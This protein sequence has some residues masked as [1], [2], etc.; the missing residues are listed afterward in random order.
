MSGDLEGLS[1]TLV[2]QKCAMFGC[3]QEYY[4][5][6]AIAPATVVKL[7][8]KH[9]VEEGGVVEDGKGNKELF[10]A[11]SAGPANHQA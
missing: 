8:F 3:R 6:L 5:T 1:M 11:G 9:F 7:C 4:Q 10:P 2:T